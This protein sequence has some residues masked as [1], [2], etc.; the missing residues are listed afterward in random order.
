MDLPEGFG[1]LRIVGCYQIL[2]RTFGFQDSYFEIWTEL[3]ILHEDLKLVAA[4]IEISR[5]LRT[6]IVIND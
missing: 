4:W 2:D 6:A 1:T 3:E 5:S